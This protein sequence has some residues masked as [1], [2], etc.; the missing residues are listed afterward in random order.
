MFKILDLLMRR[1]ILHYRIEIA[2]AWDGHV[3]PLDI[4]LNGRNLCQTV[5]ST[6]KLIIV[7]KKAVAE[8]S[9]KRG[10]LYYG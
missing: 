5:K 6:Q 4:N 1:I 2:T 7:P 8:V 10:R 9:F 3:C